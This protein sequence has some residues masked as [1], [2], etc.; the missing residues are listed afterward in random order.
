MKYRVPLF[1]SYFSTL[2]FQEGKHSQ[3]ISQIT[4]NE[5]RALRQLFLRFF[6]AGISR[7]P[8]TTNPETRELIHTYAVI[9]PLIIMCQNY[10]VYFLMSSEYRHVFKTMLGMKNTQQRSS[11]RK[12]HST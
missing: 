6:G 2:K 11:T 4:I 8:F 3:K 9:P 12:G 5:S 7:I 1:F 10:Y